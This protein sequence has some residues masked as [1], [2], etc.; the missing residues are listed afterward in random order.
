MIEGYSK[1]RFGI[2][3]Q[4]NPAPFEYGEDYYNIIHGRGE[5]N[6]RMAHLRY[7]YMVGVLGTAPHSLLDV[8][9]GDGSFLKVC[10]EKVSYCC[11]NDIYKLH[12]PDGCGFVEDITAMHYDIV[13]F[14]DSLEHFPGIDF[15]RDMKCSTFY[16]TVPDYKNMGDFEFTNWKH[17]KPDEHIF[18][19]SKWSLENLFFD[20]GYELLDS[21]HIEDVIR[22]GHD[23]ILSLIFG[24]I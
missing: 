3:K 10:K 13:C 7:G 8:G 4:D 15:L 22:G 12:I 17:R 21:S 20:M 18:H 6:I 16:I 14:H 5:L 2:V 9:Y 19:F 11:G 1:D 24:Q 23:N